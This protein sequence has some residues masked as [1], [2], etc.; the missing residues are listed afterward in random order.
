MG[1]KPKTCLKSSMLEQI[2]TQFVN[3]SC[4]HRSHCP[5]VS[6][7]GS[8]PGTSHRDVPPARFCMGDTSF[9]RVTLR[10]INLIVYEVNLLVRNGSGERATN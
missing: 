8:V 3:K 4:S 7:K 1:S 10:H 5:E 6:E 9:G 2:V